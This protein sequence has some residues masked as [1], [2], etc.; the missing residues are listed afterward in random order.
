MKSITGIVF[1][2]IWFATSLFAQDTPGCTDPQA[3]NYDPEADINDGSCTYNPTIYNPSLRHL[4]PAD[5]EETSGLVYEDGF[6]WTI[7]DSGDGPILYK[8]DTTDGT[9]LQEVTLSNAVNVDWEALAQDDENIYIGD[10]G[11]NSGTRDDLG[12]YIVKKSDLPESGDGNVN[13]EHLTFTYPD[14]KKPANRGQN[15]FDCEALIAL[16]DSLY[17]FSKNWGDN[18]TKLY[19]L[20][21]TAGDYTAEY[22]TTYDVAG[23]VTGADYNKDSK[24]VTLVGY[25]NNNFVPFLWLLFDYHD[26]NLFSGNKRRI[27]MLGVT[28]NQM[29]A[30]AYMI[31]KNG[32]ITS[33]GSVL[34]TQSAFSFFTGT[35]TD[36][37]STGLGLKE[38]KGFDFV[39]SPNP[40]NSGSLTVFIEKLP[41]GDYQ[42]EVFDTA[43]NLVQ[44]KSYNLRTE[45][46]T[47]KVHLEVS[48]LNPGLYF[49]RM[50]SVNTIVEKKFVKQ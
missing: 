2:L 24:E 14:F 7:N 10:F 5:V 11:N 25:T 21:K 23:L 28:A 34:F 29:E 45:K 4:L 41:R 44:I 48:H 47:V 42:I 13:S 17:L 46:S 30:I 8:L 43:G 26:N 20:P 36:D 31:G 33:E 3:N 27:D 15:N 49:V 32:V 18:Q 50:K 35:W 37:T 6:Q 9:V 1:L 40:V 39:L 19:R 22:L 12:I 38:V 16:D